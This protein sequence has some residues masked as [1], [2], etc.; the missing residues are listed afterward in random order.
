[1]CKTQ[2]P[3]N[4]EKE[5]QNGVI[6]MSDATFLWVQM[7]SGPEED[8]KRLLSRQSLGV[9]QKSLC[10]RVPFSTDKSVLYPYE[11]GTLSLP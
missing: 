7:A 8:K 1:M 2:I 3:N 6:Y 4:L 11:K 5:K 9:Q 10:M